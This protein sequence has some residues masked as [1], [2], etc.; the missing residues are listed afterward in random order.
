MKLYV[1]PIETACNAYCNFCITK[2]RKHAQKEILDLKDLRKTL[3]K[4][5]L[6]K[7]EITGGGEPMLHPAIEKIIDVCSEK[8]KT[9]LYT[10]GFLVRSANNLSKLEYLCISRM[11]QNDDENQRIM[12]ISYDFNNILELNVNIKLS[13]LLHKSGISSLL[14]LR[15]YLEWAMNKKNVKKVVVRQLFDYDLKGRLGS[16]FVS[17]EKLFNNMHVKNYKI[18]DGNPIFNFKNLEVEFECRSCSCE[19][20]NPVLHADGRLYGGWGEL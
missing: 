9:Q 20:Q 14:E 16:E 1:I 8:A 6:E 10:N 2:F 7:I 4:Q 5:S 11:H 19:V 15:N 17:T 18:I 12:G 3:E 13:L